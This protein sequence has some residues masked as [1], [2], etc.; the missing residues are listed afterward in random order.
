MYFQFEI[1]IF[2]RTKSRERGFILKQTNKKRTTI[3]KKNLK[4]VYYKKKS[5]FRMEYKCTLT[6]GKEQVCNI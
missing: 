5:Y 6:L 2:K 1:P 3:T 4:D